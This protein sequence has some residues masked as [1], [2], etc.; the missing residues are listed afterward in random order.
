MYH[1]SQEQIFIFFFIIGIIIGIIFDIFRASRKVFKTSDNLTLIE[2]ILFLMI[3][4]FLLIISIIK[5]NNGEIR[6]YLFIAIFLGILI[7]SLTISKMCVIILTGF[8]EICKKI[9]FIPFFL[10]KNIKNCIKK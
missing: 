5:L 9:L 4:G 2:D 8:V 6:F 10:F 1:F 3:S 7:Y